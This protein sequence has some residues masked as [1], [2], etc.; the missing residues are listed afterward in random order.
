MAKV[1]ME[2]CLA[3]AS[4]GRLI[5]DWVFEIDFNHGL[6][7]ADLVTEDCIY[8]MGSGI[9]QGRQAVVQ[10]YRERYDRLSVEADGVPPMRH[11]NANLRVDF[12]G[13]DE[14]KITFGLLFF[15]AEGNPAGNRHTDAAAVADVWMECRCEADGH[16]RISQFASDQPFS[17]TFP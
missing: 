2:E 4:V 17:R 7:I 11:L 14:V 15:T 8:H 6:N 13:P 5:N 10:S 9:K 16:W 3:I 1:T 12:V